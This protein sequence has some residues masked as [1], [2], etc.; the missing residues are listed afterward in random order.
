MLLTNI[1]SST[2][3]P[4]DTTVFPYRLVGDEAFALKPYMMRPYGGKCLDCEKE[5]VF[6][7]RLSR[8]RRVKE[9]YFGQSALCSPNCNYIDDCNYMYYFPRYIDCC[10][11]F[12]AVACV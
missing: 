6:N 3:L 12:C 1:P 5:K 9:N 7:Y 8:A 2:P 4:G 10:T 11:G